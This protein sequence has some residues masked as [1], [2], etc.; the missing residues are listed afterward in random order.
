VRSGTGQRAKQLATAVLPGLAGERVDQCDEY[1]PHGKQVYG[2]LRLEHG[3]KRP[4]ECRH[5]EHEE[6]QPDIYSAHNPTQDWSG[7]LNQ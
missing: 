1:C 6:K 7:H 3:G 2:G 5:P 4:A